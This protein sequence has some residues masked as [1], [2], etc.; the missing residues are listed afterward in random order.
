MPLGIPTRTDI[1]LFWYF[2]Q[3]L[4]FSE[5]ALFS[6]SSADS[7]R[8]TLCCRHLPSLRWGEL[9]VPTGALNAALLSTFL[10]HS[11]HSS[12]GI[13]YVQVHSLF[14]CIRVNYSTALLQCTTLRF[15]PTLPC[16]LRPPSGKLT[17]WSAPQCPAA[18]LATISLSSSHNVL[19]TLFLLY[20]SPWY[21]ASTQ[22]FVKYSS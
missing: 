21:Q 17:P 19:S 5:F 20:W 3:L 1:L 18:N 13:N 6:R 10:S 14:Q 16:S 7:G 22:I 12:V 8:H 15:C 4:F 2:I 11:A 9:V